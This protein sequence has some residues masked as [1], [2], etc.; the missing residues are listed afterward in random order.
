MYVAGEQLQLITSMKDQSCVARVTSLPSSTV[1]RS[2]GEDNIKQIFVYA[3]SDSE[4]SPIYNVW[5]LFTCCCL[6]RAGGSKFKIIDYNI[7]M[8]TYQ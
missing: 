6:V 1:D 3:N 2:T 7:I 8:C 4:W 5:P